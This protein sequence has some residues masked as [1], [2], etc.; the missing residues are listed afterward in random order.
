M[1]PVLR[2]PFCVASLPFFSFP[3]S[4]AYTVSHKSWR[5]QVL[6]CSRYTVYVYTQWKKA[7]EKEE[8]KKSEPIRSNRWIK[9]ACRWKPMTSDG[10]E[11]SRLNAFREGGSGPI[12]RSISRHMAAGVVFNCQRYISLWWC[13]YTRGTLGRTLIRAHM[14]FILLY[15]CF[16]R[17]WHGDSVLSPRLYSHV[18][19]AFQAEIG[20]LLGQETRRLP[21][22]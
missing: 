6:T 13:V 7:G 1:F 8:E 10:K 19:P 11:I 18:T 21:R 4:F 22:E 15:F 16:H 14:D 2:A 17:V 12:M 9:I 5:V 3:S 20:F